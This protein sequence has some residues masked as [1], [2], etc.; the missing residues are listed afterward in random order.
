MNLLKRWIS[1][2][3]HVTHK[4][5]LCYEKIM[6]ELANKFP[7]L[8]VEDEAVSRLFLKKVLLQSGFSVTAV[9]NGAQ[10]IKL[11][12]ETFFPIVITDWMMPEM[13]GLELCKIIRERESDDYVFIVLLTAKNAQEDIV[14]GLESGADDYL[15]KPVHKAELLARLHAGLRI[16]QLEQSLKSANDQ[17]KLLSITD[18]L[19]QVYNRGYLTEFLPKEIKRSRRY[20]LSLSIIFCD[21]DFFKNINDTYGHN[22]GDIILKEFS[23]LLQ[24]HI[25]EHVDWIARFGGEEFIIVLP[26]TIPENAYIVAERMRQDLSTKIIKIDKLSITMTASFGISG[27]KKFPDSLSIIDQQLINIADEALYQSKEEGRNKVKL[28]KNIE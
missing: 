10:A 6:K 28:G 13:N 18:T 27:I 17:I 12:N 22:V 4:C 25:R 8:L 16:L 7:V 19:T 2:L 24:N 5:Y 9:E 1:C 11:F 21:I 15:I 3:F 14:M 26:E 20:K 23:L